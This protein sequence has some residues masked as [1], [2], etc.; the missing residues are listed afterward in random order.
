MNRNSH[1]H[2][3]TVVLS[4]GAPPPQIPSSIAYQD[5]SLF[6]GLSKHVADEDDEL[7]NYTLHYP[8]THHHQEIWWWFTYLRLLLFLQYF[9]VTA[10]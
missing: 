4:S 8:S 5:S 6:Y 10:R 2:R 1:S 9:M 3:S 7:S